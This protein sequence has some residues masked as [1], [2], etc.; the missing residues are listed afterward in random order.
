MHSNLIN[1]NTATDLTICPDFGLIPFLGQLKAYH[2]SHLDQCDRVAPAR[3]SYWREDLA[4]QVYSDLDSVNKAPRTGVSLNK[5]AGSLGDSSETKSIQETEPKLARGWRF[6]PNGCKM[7]KTSNL[8]NAS[9][10]DPY[11]PTCDSIASPAAAMPDL[12]HRCF[13]DEV[14]PGLETLDENIT[15]TTHTAAVTIPHKEPDT[16]IEL[17]Y[18]ADQFLDLLI[19]SADKELDRYNAVY[20][21]LGQWS[22]SGPAAEGQRSTA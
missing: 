21:N 19:A 9:S 4:L 12:E 18:R 7:A 8:P 17:A 5:E 22:A 20:F 13:D 10:K 2:E 1:P 16:Q 6:V 15:T 3:R 11:M 14:L